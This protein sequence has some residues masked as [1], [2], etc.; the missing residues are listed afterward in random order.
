MEENVSEVIVV[1]SIGNRDLTYRD[2]AG[3]VRNPGVPRDAT[4]LATE[5][6]LQDADL[7]TISK[8]LLRCSTDGR[9]AANRFE[10]PIL[11]P[12]LEE[13]LRQVPQIDKLLMLVTDQTDPEHRKSDT[14]HCGQLLAESATV[15]FPGKVACADP[16][17]L[18]V[19]ADPQRP[20]VMYPLIRQKLSAL[21]AAAH[22]DAA[23][24]ALASGGTA[25]IK[26]GLRHAAMNVFR[27]RC[28]VIQVDMPTRGPA[29]A[30]R[31]VDWEPYLEDVARDGARALVEK[32]NFA[33][34]LD[35]LKAFP[36][37][38]WPDAAIHL[39]QHADARVSLDAG[40]ACTEAAAAIGAMRSGSPALHAA[41]NGVLTRGAPASAI[42]K[43]NEVRFLVELSLS[44]KR[45]ADA[46]VRIEQFRETARSV[47]SL[48]ALDDTRFS[49]LAYVCAPLPTNVV[50]ACGKTTGD[51]TLEGWLRANRAACGG[52]KWRMRQEGD[53]RT[54]FS[55]AS[56]VAVQPPAL[57]AA[58]RRTVIRSL[59]HPAFDALA[60]VRNASIHTTGGVSERSITGVVSLTD[61]RARLENTATALFRSF[62]QPPTTYPYESLKQAI[63]DLLAP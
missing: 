17:F 19:D 63:V 23:F 53:K 62:G 11:R 59:G 21:L 36:R 25:A 30:A 48:G 47:F 9:I 8:E 32:G 50:T 44:Q 1:A 16:R 55:F 4:T 20:D 34:A 28:S 58:D 18:V 24:Y 57:H 27:D 10:F 60:A 39:L 35:V 29:G 45:Y 22:D 12:G 15:A 46:L 3:H 33:G 43:V 56:A 61:L 38:R 31:V 13:V 7:R 26:D 2:A 54:L 37:G 52:G 49:F 14:V 41:L 40:R 5:L 51:L 6:G 42:A